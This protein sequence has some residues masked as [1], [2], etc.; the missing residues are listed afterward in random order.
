MNLW[1][2]QSILEG[3][4]GVIIRTGDNGMS[5]RSMPGWRHL[6]IKTPT[7]WRKQCGGPFH[8]CRREMIK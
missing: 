8:Y 2:R 4:G 7:G 1:W 3:S 5:S 6:W